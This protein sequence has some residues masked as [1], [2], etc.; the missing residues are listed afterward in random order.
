L[1]QSARHHHLAVFV[2]VFESFFVHFRTVFH[3]LISQ[4]RTQGAWK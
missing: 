2:A 3:V 1:R 4:R